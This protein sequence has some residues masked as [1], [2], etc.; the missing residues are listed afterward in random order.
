MKW[1]LSL[2][3]NSYTNEKIHNTKNK[4]FNKT[5]QNQSEFYEQVHVHDALATFMY[6]DVSHL[7]SKTNVEVPWVMMHVTLIVATSI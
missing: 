5:V 6:T 7:K 4:A 1:L 2:I 3:S